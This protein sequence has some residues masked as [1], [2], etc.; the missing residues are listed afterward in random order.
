MKKQLTP[1]QTAARDARRAQFRTLCK[2]V[3]A[4]SDAQRAEL[5]N[6]AGAVLTCDGRALSLHNT[7]LLF[8]Q[9][10]GVSMVGGFR[11]WIRAGRCVRKGQHGASI[12]IPLGAGKADSAAAA[13]PDADGESGGRRF[14]TATV[15]D[16]SQTAE[17]GAEDCAPVTVSPETAEQLGI[18]GL[19][20]VEIEEGSR[21]ILAA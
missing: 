5:A 1:E 9:L 2:S 3:A 20:G 16:I 19:P 17:L 18:G 11:Q 12:W 6:R 8:M 21:R 4:M 7:L 14:G 10:P 13:A 15:F